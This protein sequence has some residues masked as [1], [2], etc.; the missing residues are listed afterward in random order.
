M[1]I[2]PR[3]RTKFKSGFTLIE[4]L[5]VIA[6]LAAIL[7]PVFA[8]AREKARQASCMSNLR[9]IGLAMMQYTQDSD[10][11]MF[12]WLEYTASTL[13]FWDGMVDFGS[14]PP[15]YEPGKG[16]LQPYMKNIQIQDCPTAAG[17]VE[18]LPFDVSKGL[19]IWT[20][21]GPNMNLFPNNAGTYVGL[22]M[23]EIQASSDTVFLA[24]AAEFNY[25]TPRG[26]TRTNILRA[27]SQGSSNLHGR[28]NGMANV[29]WVDGHV[30]SLKPTPPTSTDGSGNTVAAYAANNL[31]DLKPS[32]SVSS[33]QDYYFLLTK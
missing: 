22:P 3:S 15:K 29:L 27:P 21:Y 31:G 25:N 26:L 6:I 14:G 30:K 10:E 28:H 4:L 17:L 13:N 24:D 23:A 16:L 12:P 19:P 33:N 1:T 8:Q 18:P 2:A 32:G 5:V 11:T 20:A 7:F 9:Q